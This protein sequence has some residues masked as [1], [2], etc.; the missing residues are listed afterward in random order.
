MAEI[1]QKRIAHIDALDSNQITELI[2]SKAKA[3]N[4]ALPIDYVIP[5]AEENELDKGTAHLTLDRIGLLTATHLVPQS[6]LPTRIEN[7]L[8]GAMSVT[9]SG[10]TEKWTF[11]YDD[12]TDVHKYVCPKPTSGQGE[13]LPTIEYIYRDVKTVGGKTIYTQYRYV[14]VE[15]TVGGDEE[16]QFVPIPSDLILT[17]GEGTVIHDND[18]AYTRQVDI[19]IGTVAAATGSTVIEIQ[20]KKLV[21]TTSGVTGGSYPASQSTTP[22]FGSNPFSVPQITVNPTGHVTAVVDNNTTKITIPATPARAGAAGLVKIGSDSDVQPISQTNAIGTVP[23]SANDYVLVAAADHT[24]KA[25]TFTLLHTNDN[26]DT[27][28]YDGTAANTFTYDFN[29]FL[30]VPLPSSGPSAAGDVLAIVND[31]GLK[32]SWQPMG[33]LIAPSYAFVQASASSVS[34]SGT[35]VT[36]G[37]VDAKSSDMSVSNNQI[38]GLVSGK[39]YAVSFALPVTPSAANAYL[40]ELTF[41][42]L[43]GST[44]KATCTQAIDES[45]TGVANHFNATIFYQ[46][47]A[48]ACKFTV[49]SSR[50]GGPTWSISGGTIQLAEVK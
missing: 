16:G 3:A 49:A 42:I 13:E 37:T 22:G 31:N 7:V 14:P 17:D 27:K 2:K 8:D 20:N 41:S 40:D 50:S 38:S 4:W 46:A 44:V 12:G 35:T 48:T 21:H 23:S 30:K 15:S 36:L 28:N 33:S 6:M 29:N 43:E 34:T 45:I 18:G 10:S 47:G 9:G 11:T 5:D 32:A 19:N 24:H 39:I 25:E 26:P 1:E